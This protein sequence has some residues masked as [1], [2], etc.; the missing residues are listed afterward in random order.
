[1]ADQTLKE[2]TAKGLFWGG[3]NNGVQQLLNLLFGI[4]LARLL[5]PDDYGMVAMLSIFSLI[6]AS[7]QESGFTA[8]LANKKEVK[9]EDYN[10]VFWFNIGLSALL[11]LL[12]FFAAPLPLHAAGIPYLQDF[13]SIRHLQSTSGSV[14]LSFQRA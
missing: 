3:L 8:A 2:K 7:L 12:L 14:R 11:Y 9:H 4:F 1:M 5:S 6:A 13:R 10:A